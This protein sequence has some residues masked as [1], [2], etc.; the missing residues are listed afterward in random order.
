MVHNWIE[1]D[2]MGMIS[3]NAEMTPRVL[4]VTQAFSFERCMQKVPEEA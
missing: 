1:A 2:V 3:P 4:V